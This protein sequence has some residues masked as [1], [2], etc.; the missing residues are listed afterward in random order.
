MEYVHPTSTVDFTVYIDPEQPIAKFVVGDNEFILKE[1][2]WSDWKAVDFEFVPMVVSASAI[3]RFYLKQVRPEFQLYVTPLQINPD[4]P[5][6]PISTPDKWSHHL[7]HELGYFYTQELPEDTKA[8]THG[9]FTGP[10][11]WEQSQF[12]YHERRRALDYFLENYEEGFLFF[13]YSSVDMGCHMLWQYIDDSHPGFDDDKKLHESIKTLYR[14]MDESLGRVM[15]AID[16]ETTLIVMS[17][18]GFAPFYWGVNLNTWLLEKGYVKLR[19]PTIQGRYPA[20]A[21]VDWS[22]TKAYA[23]GLNGLYVNLEGREERGI[24]K[25][26]EEY[27]KLLDQLERDLLEMVDP[28]NGNHAVTKVVRTHRDFH[29]PYIDVGPDI[30]VG[31]NW[32]YR[33]SWDSPL[34]SFP[35]E[36]F[37]DNLDEWSGDHA[38]DNRLVP[39]VLLTNKKITLD[40]PALYDLTVAILDEYGVPKTEEMIG[41]DCLGDFI[42]KGE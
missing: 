24:V 2:E 28:R 12:V 27:E 11:F 8:F 34:G 29:G 19:D 16:D 26:G 38:M 15:Q 23:L 9:I 40:E 36:I 21:N 1:G 3:G 13:Y 20:F 7:C 18:H 33:S 31:Y 4:D 25:P 41:D 17:D 6:M 14:E 42:S 32:G 37:V 30:I 10:E 39:G 35:R 22:Q 5:V